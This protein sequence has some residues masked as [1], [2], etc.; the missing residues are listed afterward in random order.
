MSTEI[1]LHN[2]NILS[3]KER[4]LGYKMLFDLKSCQVQVRGTFQDK[5]GELAF[6]RENH[7]LDVSTVG[8]RRYLPIIIDGEIVP[9]AP[10]DDIIQTVKIS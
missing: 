10:L 8:R 6:L 7:E 3:L 4:I 2:V 9:L 1:I 5:S